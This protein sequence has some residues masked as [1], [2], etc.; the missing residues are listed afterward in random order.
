[1]LSI[2]RIKDIETSKQVALLLQGENDRLHKRLEEL[3]RE[4][5]K[6]KGLDEA[7]QLELE[8]MRMQEQMGALQRKLFGASSEKRPGDEG[9]GDK[10]KEP[11]TGHGPKEQPELPI[12]EQTHELPADEMT[13]SAC[14]GTLAEWEGQYEES[15]E[16][17]VVERQFMLRKHLRKKYRCTCGACVKTAPA[18]QKPIPGGRYST[19]FA[20]EVAA[21]KYLDHLPLERQA[22]IMKREG[23]AVDSQTLWDQVWALARL[24]EP[25]YEKIRKHVLSQEVAHGDETPWYLLK[26]G[27]R[28]KWYAWAAACHDAVYFHFD[29]RR[30]ADAADLWAGYKGWLVVDGYQTYLTL[31]KRKPPGALKLS[32][33]WAHARRKYVEAE[34][35]YPDECKAVLDLIRELY[36]VE[37]EAPDPMPLKGDEQAQALELRAR[38]RTE[39]SA[40]IIE[41]IREWSAVQF[42]LPESSL[43]KAI[44]YMTNHWHGLTRFLYDPR[45]PL[46]N[47]LVEREIRSLAV[48][49]KNF[50]GCKSERGL[51]A[52][53]ILYTLIGT[54]KLQ[55]AE[56]KAYL[57]A[58]ARAALRDPATAL[59]PIELD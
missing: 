13:C 17:T 40:A 5:S 44:A 51:K 47:N 52:A 55:G 14:G 25:T 11:R 54:A 31:A 22:R 32:Y 39:R 53:A 26:A 43:M 18:P 6:L 1:M 34:A 37:R 35:N 29:R 27:G 59:L 23:L 48:G 38:L 57:L 10:K 36:M 16:V 12:V 30:S 50:Y 2:E 45:L 3:T 7:K 21:Q 49:R 8:M 24:Y 58:L 28:E 56:P 19:E 46:D 20:V 33:C 41:R 4:V 15:Q 9:D 42:A